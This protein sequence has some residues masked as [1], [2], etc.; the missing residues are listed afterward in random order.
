MFHSKHLLQRSCIGAL[1]LIVL[2]VAAIVPAQAQ[3]VT[4]TDENGIIYNIVDRTQ[5]TVNVSAQNATTLASAAELKDVVIPATV[6]DHSTNA[7]DKDPWNVTGMAD[8]AFQKAAGLRSITIVAPFDQIKAF[9]FNDCANLESVTLPET[10]T[11]IY[12]QAFYNC[13]NLKSVSG[14][15]NVRSIYQNAFGKCS[16]LT[17]IIL[18][19]TLT[20][21]GGGAFQECTS[22]EKITVPG[23]LKTLNNS[24]FQGCTSLASVTLEEGLETIGQRAFEGCTNLVHPTFPSTLRALGSYAF[25]L[26]DNLGTVT[27]RNLEYAGQ[28]YTEST[29]NEIEFPKSE[30]KHFVILGAGLFQKVKGLTEVTVKG[31]TEVPASTFQECPDLTT[32]TLTDDIGAIRGNA[33]AGCKNLATVNFSPELKYIG[34][35]AF[36][37]CTGLTAVT[38]PAIMT[39]I[40]NY[41]FN[42]CS[43]LTDITLPAGAELGTAIF[44]GCDLK[45]ITFPAEPMGAIA[46]NP[47]G[48]QPSIKKM[49]IPGW[50]TTVPEQIFHE[51]TALAEITFSEGVEAIGASAAYSCPALETIILPSTLK[52]IQG[53]NRD[54]TGAFQHCNKLANIRLTAPGENGEARLLETNG[55]FP[56]ALTEIGHYAFSNCK[57]LA[58]VTLPDVLESIGENAFNHC[59]ILEIPVFPESLKSIGGNAFNSCKADGTVT[60]HKGMRVGDYAFAYSSPAVINLPQTISSEDEKISF[61]W[62]VFKDNNNIRTFTFPDWMDAIPGGFCQNWRQL[63][64]IILPAKLSRIEEY[65]FSACGMLHDVALPPTIKYLDKFCFSNCGST[66]HLFGSITLYEGTKVDESAFQSTYLTEIIFEGCADFGKNV[67]NNVTTIEKIAFPACMETIPEGFCQNWKNLTEV[68]IPEGVKKISKS[69]FGNCSALKSITIPASLDSICD[70]A[71]YNSGLEE[72]TWPEKGI[73]GFGKNVFQNCKFQQF[74]IPSWLAPVPEAFLQNNY[75]L[76]ELTWE[77]RPADEDSVVV[78]PNAF[79]NLRLTEISFPEDKDIVL[80]RNAFANCQQA[81]AI[82]WP[83]K[84]KVIIRGESVFSKC[85]KLQAVTIPDYMEWLPNSTFNDCRGIVDIDM[86]RGLKKLG[87]GCFHYNTSLKTIRWSPVLEQIGLSC[88]DYTGVETID[89]PAGIS[90]IPAWCFGSCPNL[91]KVTLPDDIGTIGVGAFGDCPNLQEINFPSSLREIGG[92]AFSSDSKLTKLEFNEG[93]EI[94]SSSAFMNC[95]G[96]TTVNFPES[97]TYLGTEAFRQC[98]NLETVTS[99]AADLSIYDRCFWDCTQLKSFTSTGHV[100]YLGSGAFLGLQN[101]TDFICPE[102]DYVDYVGNSA[103][104]NC[105]QLKAFPYLGKSYVGQSAFARCTSLKSL[106]L[107]YEGSLTNN[108]N[109]ITRNYIKP[110]FLL[111]ATS[112]QSVVWPATAPWFHLY[113]C[114]ISGAPLEA[115]SYSYATDVVELYQTGSTS[116]ERNDRTIFQYKENEWPNPQIDI[117]ATPEKSR[118]MV[119][120]GEKWKYLEAG[121]GQLFTIDEM[122]EPQCN[123]TGDIFSTFDPEMNVNHYTVTLRWD[124]NLSDLNANGPTKMKIYREATGGNVLIADLIFSKPEKNPT[125]GDIEVD[126]TLNGKPNAFQGDFFYLADKNNN[127]YQTEYMAQGAKLI[128]DPVTEK[129]KELNT[130][131]R[132]LSWFCLVDKFDSPDL[133]DAA[134]VPSTYRYHGE[135]E[136]YDYTELVN[137]DNYEV[138]EATGLRYHTENRTLKNVVSPSTTVYTAMALPSPYFQG[139]YTT[140]DVKADTDF[141]LGATARPSSYMVEYN[142]TNPE[143]MKHRYRY[144][145]VNSSYYTTE[146]VLSGVEVKDVTDPSNTTTVGKINIVNTSASPSG[147]VNLIDKTNPDKRYQTVVTSRS[148]GTFGSPVVSMPDVPAMSASISVGFAD[149]IRQTLDAEE[150]DAHSIN[151]EGELLVPYTAR[152]TINNLDASAMGYAQGELTADDFVIAL[153]RDLGIGPWT[154]P[155]ENSARAAW[156]QYPETVLH[157][158]GDI[159]CAHDTHCPQCAAGDGVEASPATGTITLTDTYDV[160]TRHDHSVNFTP[161]VYIKVPRSVN[162]GPDRWMIAEAPVEATLGSVTGVEDVTADGAAGTGFDPSQVRWYDLRGVEVKDPQPGTLYLRVTPAGT[163]KTVYTL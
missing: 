149:H 108:D 129:R 39:K 27:I 21:L 121:Y 117:K 1:W 119:R 110:F 147:K 47:F 3:V 95:Q 81:T 132:F 61:G 19:S 29:I 36:D 137:N 42:R 145:P 91:T 103:F 45:S 114:D 98:R 56:D 113:G 8:R 30:D 40:D 104:D 122:K 23:S 59:S 107:P 146:M 158:D 144:R 37:G 12:Q 126:V 6:I 88:F 106:T 13:P 5:R 112:V 70:L 60:L 69:V 28:V 48:K 142:M 120:R 130:A 85:Q 156:D 50:M 54:K 62:Y 24:T 68:T 155:G 31:Y 9:T 123:L 148:R 100:N 102:G 72:I 96:L 128:Y 118:L 90:E 138:D 154:A 87:N 150:Y 52:Q 159:A 2:L 93:L 105:P 125:T 46:T 101:F 66:D 17:D 26:C 99:D 111:G 134:K 135:I 136:G 4:V 77:A 163:S 71:F 43:S 32:V 67:F 74:T 20:E 161:R 58:S 92:S 131:T 143:V 33:F 11:T 18:P 139:I 78:K 127:I 79:E 51:W 94:I 34:G 157:F 84:S 141:N 82:R 49:T 152:I 97:L 162:P 7:T 16:S 10:M 63:E 76:T 64:T 53:I 83:E 133:N 57:A 38:L 86:G 109:T 124:V 65:A 35:Y 55:K 41:A 115:I 22:L 25:K 116:Q 140:D 44:N 89:Y 160:A 153:R 73:K 14:I 80:Q 151:D 75:L 15:D